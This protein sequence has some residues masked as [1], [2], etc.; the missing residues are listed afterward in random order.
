MMI[1]VLETAY[2]ELPGVSVTV[3]RDKREEK[4]ED[5]RE[6]KRADTHPYRLK[7]FYIDKYRNIFRYLFL[8]LVSAGV[9]IRLVVGY[10]TPNSSHSRHSFRFLSSLL[11]ARFS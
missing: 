9:V 7:F 11:H 8:A 4:R 10:Q 2:I 3:G 6:D 5:K 1:V